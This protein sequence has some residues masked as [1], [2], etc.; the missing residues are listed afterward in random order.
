MLM[1]VDASI[2]SMDAVQTVTLPLQDLSSRDV[3]VT[4][5]SLAVVLME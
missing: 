2:L 3:H 5:I 1:V 4:H